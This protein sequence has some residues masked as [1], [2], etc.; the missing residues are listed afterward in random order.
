MT[1]RDQRVIFVPAAGLAIDEGQQRQLESLL[2]AGAT[3]QKIVRGCHS[4]R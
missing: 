3:P 1:I 4:H 2:R